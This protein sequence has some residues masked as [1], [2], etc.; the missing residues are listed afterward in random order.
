MLASFFRA[1]QCPMI[2]LQ[3]SHDPLVLTDDPGVIL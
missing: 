3:T 1:V 2:H